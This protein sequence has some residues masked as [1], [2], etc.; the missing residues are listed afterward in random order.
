MENTT[1]T[2]KET[3]MNK[4]SIK[5]VIKNNSKKILKGAAIGAAGIVIGAIGM[6][7][8]KDKEIEGYRAGYR[9][10]YS[11][12]VEEV[13]E[14]IEIMEDLDSMIDTKDVNDMSD[15]EYITH[16]HNIEIIPDEVMNYVENIEQENGELKDKVDFLERDIEDLEA[17]IL[18]NEK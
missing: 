10:G 6:K 8:K 17:Q 12:A 11:T 1:N 14:L 9:E 4:E 15:R 18:G 7:M 2:T 16:L 3:K 5:E 13:E